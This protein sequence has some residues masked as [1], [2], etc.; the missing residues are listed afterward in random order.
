MWQYV[1]WNVVGPAQRFVS[2]LDTQ[3]WVIISIV[4]VLI[5]YFALRETPA[6]TGR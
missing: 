3:D 5:G 2:R 6:A 1:S 4:A